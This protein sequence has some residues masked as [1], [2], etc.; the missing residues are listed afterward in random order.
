MARTNLRKFSFCP[1]G[2]DVTIIP[3][4]NVELVVM[5]AALPATILFD[6]QTDW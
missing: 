1:E 5:I 6:S 4:T 3:V 2:V